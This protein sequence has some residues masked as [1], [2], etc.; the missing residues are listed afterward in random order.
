MFLA[1]KSHGQRS[2]ADYS[3]WGCKESDRTEQ[4]NNKEL[5]K[6]T[7]ESSLPSSPREDTVRSPSVNQKEN[8]H[9]TP[10]R[11][12][13]ALILDFQSFQTVRN[14]WL[15]ISHPFCGVLLQQ[16]KRKEAVFYSN[17]KVFS[18]WICTFCCFIP[19]FSLDCNYQKDLCFHYLTG[20]C[21]H[22]WK[23]LISI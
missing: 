9:Q 12:A 18:T 13:A 23:L 5:I 8:P 17:F 3:P 14:K 16:P 21:S 7:P 22:T 6:E 15:L 10:S 4:L 11:L 19:I 2:P 20:Y 1:G